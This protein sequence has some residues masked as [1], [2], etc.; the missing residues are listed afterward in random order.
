MSPAVDGTNYNF[1]RGLD[2]LQ[3]CEAAEDP[4]NNGNAAKKKHP[5]SLSYA[6]LH[7]TEQVSMGNVMHSSDAFVVRTC[8]CANMHLIACRIN[9][10]VDIGI[11]R[12]AI[13]GTEDKLDAQYCLRPRAT[14][15]LTASTCFHA[16]ARDGAS[17]C[18]S[19]L[20]ARGGRLNTPIVNDGALMLRNHQ[21][22]R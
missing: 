11:P 20:S 3:E 19:S 14:V 12:C 13:S 8:R 5:D 4:P 9:L 15:K 18:F 10:T 2:D 22:R 17:G 21:Y 16:D 1:H 7:S 6:K